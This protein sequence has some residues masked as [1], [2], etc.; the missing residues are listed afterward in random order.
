[1]SELNSNEKDLVQKG[2]IVQAIFE[3]SERTGLSTK[4][5]RQIV[6]FY[7]KNLNLIQPMHITKTGDVQIRLT[8]EQL[9]KIVNDLNF[10]GRSE[11][12]VADMFDEYNNSHD[13][14]SIFFS[15]EV[16]DD[17]KN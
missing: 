6:E 9:N 5:S 13:K 16:E 8:K 2:Y 15:I 4:K 17:D 11:G 10:F 14:R 1:M 3:H 12:L 7:N